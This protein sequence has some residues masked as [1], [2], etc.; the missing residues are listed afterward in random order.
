[1]AQGADLSVDTTDSADPVTVGTE[2]VYSVA[3]ANSG[4]DAALG[5]AVTD[6]LASEVDFV[7][8]SVATYA[9]GNCAPQG[10]KKVECALGSL[11]SGG[12]ALISIRVRA[13]RE[14]T[15]TNMAEVSS[16]SPNDPNKQNDK[17]SESTLIQAPTT[18]A[19]CAGQNV[20]LIG[21]SGADTLTGSPK[22]DVIAGLGGD[23][24]ITGLDG[25]DIVCGGLGND[26]IAAGTDA[27]RVKG[28]GGNDRIRG[29]KGN[30][31]L[32]GNGGDDRLGGGAGND[33][34]RGGPGNDRC[35][36]G[37]GADTRRGCE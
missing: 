8:A 25:R 28:G 15:A 26:I 34:L 35:G 7:S 3:V 2:F 16:S 12:T 31:V 1:M 22:R 18:G 17:D 21:T 33:T 37:P 32:S 23:D 27:D 11:P 29:A 36:G 30:D 24:E 20:T 13:Q 4:P 6:T 5:V 14:G 10:P 9:E 19:T